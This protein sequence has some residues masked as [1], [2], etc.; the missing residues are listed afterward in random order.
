M[1]TGCISEV[2]FRRYESCSMDCYRTQGYDCRPKARHQATSPLP[3]PRFSHHRGGLMLALCCHL[4]LSRVATSAG[5][6]LAVEPHRDCSRS[7]YV[8]AAW[9]RHQQRLARTGTFI[10]ENGWGGGTLRRLNTNWVPVDPLRPQWLARCHSGGR[11]LRLDS[12]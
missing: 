5:S 9:C 1:Q 4:A 6:V 7:G 10:S 11:C 3:R 2:F 8:S 12:N